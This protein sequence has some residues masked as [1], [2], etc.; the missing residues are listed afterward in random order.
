[1][2]LDSNKTS[3]NRLVLNIEEIEQYYRLL[4]IDQDG[5]VTLKDYIEFVYISKNQ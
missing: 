3:E 2:L 5:L 4:D 1:M